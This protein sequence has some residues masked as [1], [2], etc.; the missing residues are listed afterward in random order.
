MESQ[1]FI[2]LVEYF[3]NSVK[4]NKLLFKLVELHSFYIS[5]FESL[6]VYKTVNKTQL[7]KSL[8]DQFPDAQEQTDGKNLVIT[9]TKALQGM[10][11]DAI[12]KRDVHNC[13][14]GHT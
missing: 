1:A 8:L 2:Q 4:K 7:K 11:K 6:G 9:F 12:K 13:E 3:G 5:R 10:V 14:K